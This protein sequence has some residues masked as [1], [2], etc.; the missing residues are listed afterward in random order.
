[1]FLL[2]KK[3]ACVLVFQTDVDQIDPDPPLAEH[4][5]QCEF[6]PTFLKCILHEHFDK[7]AIRPLKRTQFDILQ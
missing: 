3:N 4:L 2:N 6:L 7:D 1:M 5:L